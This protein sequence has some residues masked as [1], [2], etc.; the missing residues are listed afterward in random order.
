MI[1]K[2]RTGLEASK[3]SSLV[4]DLRKETQQMKKET[5]K[6]LSHVE[7]GM[8]WQNKPSPC[9]SQGRSSAKFDTYFLLFDRRMNRTRTKE[10]LAWMFSA[11]SY[12]RSLVPFPRAGDPPLLRLTSDSVGQ[13]ADVSRP[14][15]M[16][17]ADCSEPKPC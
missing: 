13:M 6:P 1:E 14:V 16:R 7:R 9:H 2:L 17:S 10:I 5:K 11:L 8:S 3:V 4:K 12:A 15:G